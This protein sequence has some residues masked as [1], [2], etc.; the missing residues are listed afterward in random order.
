[1]DA[2]RDPSNI[3][4]N[5]NMIGFESF[6]VPFSRYLAALV[7]GTDVPVECEFKNEKVMVHSGF[8]PDPASYAQWLNQISFND[9]LKNPSTDSTIAEAVHRLRPLTRDT[10]CVGLASIAIHDFPM[11]FLS[12]R[13][14]GGFVHP[15]NRGQGAFVGL[16]DFEPE[17]VKREAKHNRARG[18]ALDL[19]MQDQI[20]ILLAKN[21]SPIEGQLACAN[22]ADLGYDPLPLFDSLL[23]VDGGNTIILKKD[24]LA[25]VVK[26]K[27]L[28]F[29]L[30]PIV[31]YHIEAYHDY[32]G[33]PN[34]L[35]YRPL[36]NCR[37]L[38]AKMEN[39]QPSNPYS[40]VSCVHRLLVNTGHVPVWKRHKQVAKGQFGMLDGLAVQVND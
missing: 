37:F 24:R 38:D 20:K 21:L 13:A 29:L 5:R 25:D 35:L 32:I 12:A 28:M 10:E 19:W 36:K 40:I 39:D 33:I 3:K 17:T 31:T 23:V 8:P 16:M 22:I 26:D 14:V 6:T 18:N 7:A 34:I 4:V 1:M 30:S 15:D 9:I 27:P 11:D 2:L